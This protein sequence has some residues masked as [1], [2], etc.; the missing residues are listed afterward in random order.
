MKKAARTF[1]S[2]R[3][4]VRISS[5]Y[6]H[7][8]A[9]LNKETETAVYFFTPAFHVFDNFS[10][11]VVEIWG[12]TFPTAEH[13]YQWKKFHS[14]NPDVS[15]KILIAKSPEKVKQI[16]HAYESQVSQKWHDEKVSVMKEILHAKLTQHSDVLERLRATG[17]RLIA[18]NSPVDSFWGV[19]ED[20]D[21]E[22]MV[23]KIWMSLR[24]E[25]I[26]TQ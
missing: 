17:D 19:G 14:S 2:C 12:V 22:N 24:D 15:E 11:H 6:P 21:G 7:T 9:N 13:A 8:S 20:G 10:A 18:E 23:G 25:I 26:T 3:F 1:G 16:S 4:C 5:M